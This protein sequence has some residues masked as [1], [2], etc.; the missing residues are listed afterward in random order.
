MAKFGTLRSEI[1]IK[2][3][4]YLF[5]V[6]LVGDIFIYSKFPIALPNVTKSYL[7]HSFF[8]PQKEKVVVALIHLPK[9]SMMYCVDGYHKSNT[10]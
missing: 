2:V 6:C 1:S 10:S 8:P 7:P 9:Y 4:S 5:F 3:G